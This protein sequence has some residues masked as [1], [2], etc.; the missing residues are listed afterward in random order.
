M[1]SIITVLIKSRPWRNWQTRTFEGRVRDHT[2]SSPVGRTIIVRAIDTFVSVAL[3]LY[4][5]INCSSS[6]C[7]IVNISI[8]LNI[9]CWF[10]VAR[11]EY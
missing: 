4:T 9:A 8:K 3:M 2:G 7:N 10:G 11:K 1:K 5:R 6:L